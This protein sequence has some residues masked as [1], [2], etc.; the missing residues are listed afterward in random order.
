MLMS[1]FTCILFLGGWLPH[2]VIFGYDCGILFFTFKLL[3][4]LFLFVGLRAILPRYRYDSLMQLG[5]KV[6][7]PLSLAM[8]IFTSCFVFVFM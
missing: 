1:G 5:W 4:L 6:F 2:I 7:L 8:V 3:L